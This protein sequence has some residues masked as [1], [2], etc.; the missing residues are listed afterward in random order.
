M[1]VREE[2]FNSAT[3]LAGS[4]FAVAGL[5]ALVSTAA[6]GGDPW[7]IASF[8]LYG[9]SMVALYLFSTLY[10]ALSGPAKRVFRKLDHTS[11]YVLIAGTYAPFALVSLRRAGGG[12][13]LAAVWALAAAGIAQEFLL[14]RRIRALSVSL[15]LFMGWLAAAFFF[16][17]ERAIGP[18]GI[19]WLL[20]GGL[21]YTAG[22][23]FYL[24]DEKYAHSHGV[25]HLFV[26]GGSVLH[27][28]AVL[29][30]VA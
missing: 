10:H 7:K 16:P 4:V 18:R 29:F 23:V 25:F 30:Y 11:I 21:L 9:V 17:L 28:V 15:Y 24:V 20:A 3:H 26:L 27:F 2:I 12:W 13:L 1:V 8:A 5:A 14:P 22:V 6:R 19:G